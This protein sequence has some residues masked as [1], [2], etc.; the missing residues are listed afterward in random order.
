MNQREEEDSNWF[1]SN[2]ENKIK[3]FSFNKKALYY[4]YILLIFVLIIY[5]L[6]YGKFV[7]PGKR[8]NYEFSGYSLYL[9]IFAGFIFI[10]HFSIQLIGENVNDENENNLYFKFAYNSRFFGI[11]IIIIAIITNIVTSFKIN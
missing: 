7:I 1:E 5:S 9:L 8:I 3:K 4:G 2:N 6:V 11:A 10:F